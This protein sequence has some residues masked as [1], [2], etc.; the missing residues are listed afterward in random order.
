MDPRTGLVARFSGPSR[1]LFWMAGFTFVVGVLGYALEDQ[2]RTAFEANQAINGLILLVFAVAVLYC[3]RQV[4]SVY[5]A[6][7]WVRR[8]TR[9]RDFDRMPRPPGLIAPMGVLLSETPGQ[10]RLSAGSS[11]SILDSV[12]G[13]MDEAGEI[14]RYLGRLLIFLGLL[15]TFW[16]LLQTVG[17]VGNAVAALSNGTG[18]EEDVALLMRALEEPIKGMGTAFSSSLFGLAGSLVIGFLEL[19]AG[20]A[21]NRFF[22]EVE[23]WI[24]SISRVSAAAGQDPNSPAYVGALLEQ[25]ADNIASLEKT[26]R[27]GEAQRGAGI[28]AVRQEIKLL[29]KTLVG[30]SRDKK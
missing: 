7:R 30:L 18:G 13:R 27:A 3:F 19:Q 29:T 26:M 8:L 16:G 15:G 23:D 1:Y 9:A 24:H 28:E 2:I 20:Q 14:T 5:P 11:Q 25:S 12:S 17:S 6:V 22:M 10:L 21:Q 4:L